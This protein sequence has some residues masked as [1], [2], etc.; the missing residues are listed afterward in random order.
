MVR[1]YLMRTPFVV[2]I[3][4]SFLLPAP[5]HA[6]MIGTPDPVEEFLQKDIEKRKDFIQRPD[7]SDS[8]KMT[9]DFQEDIRDRESAST[10]KT[11]EGKSGSA[12]WKWALGILAVGGVAALA[13]GGGGGGGGTSSTGGATVTGSW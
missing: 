5:V 4:L 7:K 8:E 13:S 11:D 10:S 12:W 2:F 3:L 9:E 1:E 6:G